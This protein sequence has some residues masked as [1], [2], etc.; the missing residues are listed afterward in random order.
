MNSEPWENP[1]E[2][3]SAPILRS[4]D[5]GTFDPKQAIAGAECR[6][7]PSITGGCSE[8]C[9]KPL[10]TKRKL[11]EGCFG[12]HSCW[13]MPLQCEAKQSKGNRSLLCTVSRKPSKELFWHHQGWAL[14]YNTGDLL[15]KGVRTRL[16][17]PGEK[18]NFVQLQLAEG[19]S[20]SETVSKSQATLAAC[21]A[22]HWCSGAVGLSCIGALSFGNWDPSLV[23]QATAEASSFTSKYGFTCWAVAGNSCRN[24]YSL[25]AKCMQLDWNAKLMQG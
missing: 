25:A 8:V 20:R 10:L 9:R 6:I 12:A 23:T 18:C 17:Q 24:S 22:G 16:L 15:G 3:Q 14:D 21:H 2:L 11:E 13:E 5:S 19:T 7:C 1:I 4:Y